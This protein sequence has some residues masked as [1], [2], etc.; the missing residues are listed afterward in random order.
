[1]L[2][3]QC[4]LLAA[5]SLGLPLAQACKKN[6]TGKR[7]AAKLCGQLTADRCL[8]SREEEGGTFDM[9][10]NYSIPAINVAAGAEE[11]AVWSAGA[12]D[13]L[14]SLPGEESRHQMPVQQHAAVP[15]TRALRCA[16]RRLGP[17]ERA[18]CVS[19]GTNVQGC[20]PWLPCRRAG[21]PG[22]PRLRRY[23]HH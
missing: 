2:H 5:H 1:M 22:H 15:W 10:W 11:Y 9:P 21:F 12:C 3:A 6:K 17:V 20:A 14:Q 23:G 7:R 18:A 4:H 19:A 8:P 16:A 13:I